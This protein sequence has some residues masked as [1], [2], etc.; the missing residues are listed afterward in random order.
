MSNHT[1]GQPT[2]CFA[3]AFLQNGLQQFNILV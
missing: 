1:K 3:F 2:Q